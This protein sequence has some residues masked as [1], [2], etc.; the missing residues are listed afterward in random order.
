MLGRRRA[1]VVL[2]APALTACA[3]QAAEVV[4][5]AAPTTRAPTAVPATPS[6]VPP[7]PTPAPTATPAPEPEEWAGNVWRGKVEVT[8]RDA[9]Q[10]VT[11]LVRVWS[12]EAQAVTANY[13]GRDQPLVRDGNSFVGLFGVERLLARPGARA[14]RF[15]LVDPSGRRV[16]RNDAADGYQVVDA[17]YPTEDLVV[18]EKT[19]ALLDQ[20]AIN[21]EEAI[22]NRVFSQWT[23]ERRWQ[24]PF[25]EPMM[26]A[27]GPVPLSSDFG[28]RRN[29]NGRPSAWPHE[30]TDYEVDTGD[31]IRACADGVVVLAQALHTRGNT[32]IVNHG[33]GVMTGYSHMFQ[34]QVQPGQEVKKGQ[35]IGLVGST[36]FVTGPHLHVEIRVRNVPV[37]PMEWFQRA[38]FSRPDL[39]SL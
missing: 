1:L 20:A 35:Q 9:R 10:G 37:E 21:A 8:P 18:D 34:W 2:S 16:T 24:G 4:P 25:G 39:A 13:E 5:T 26:S 7:T 27:A 32:V 23:P 22:V 29:I 14:L 17:E 38:P 12:T 6:P 11:V 30:G 15:T 33:W 3:P 28:T 19:L 31:P 36:G